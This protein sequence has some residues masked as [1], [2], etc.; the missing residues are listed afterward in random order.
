MKLPRTCLCYNT[1]PDYILTVSVPGPDV[2]LV[3]TN[4]NEVIPDSNKN[5]YNISQWANIFV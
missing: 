2:G 3:V 1:R 4:S 5:D